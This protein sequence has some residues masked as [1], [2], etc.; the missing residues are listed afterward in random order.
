[1]ELS[2]PNCTSKKYWSH[3]LSAPVESLGEQRRKRYRCARC[4]K[5]FSE[6][7]HLIHFRQKKADRALNAKIL[8]Y[9]VR[10]I[11]NRCIGRLLYI[12]EHCVRIRI[13]RLSQQSL[14]FQAELLSSQKIVEP[15]CM[16]GL[17]NFAGSQYDVNNIQQAIGRDSLFIYDF[18]LATMNRKGYM[19]PW[20]KRRLAEIQRDQGRYNPRAIRL[21]TK[22]LLLRL[23]QQWGLNT[24]FVLLSDEHFQYRRAINQD[25]RRFRIEHITVSSKACRNFQNILFP[26]NHADLLIRQRVAAFTRE[27]ISFSK[28]HGSMCQRYALFMISKNF[29]EPQFTKIHVRRP[30]AHLKSPAQI[31]GLTDRILSFKDIFHKAAHP[32]DLEKLSGDWQ[33]FARGTIPKE[34]NRYPHHCRRRASI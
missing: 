26:V 14:C 27:T 21:A 12:S 32:K 1:M 15:I 11:S 18:N 8:T 29:M 10:S 16:D 25:L 23:H 19:S 2:C 5:R 4:L 13:R 24:P 9:A 31:A 30:E 6:H 20:Q 28:T 22:T 3:G 7:S 33:H 34:F 17:E